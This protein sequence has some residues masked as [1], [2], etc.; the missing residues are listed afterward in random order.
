M[1]GV[2]L[3]LHVSGLV[4]LALTVTP[5]TTVSFWPPFSILLALTLGLYIY[6]TFYPLPPP[7]PSATA[8]IDTPG[9]PGVD[10]R[11]VR[12]TIFTIYGISPL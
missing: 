9:D 12:T 1:R 4:G 8:L 3:A 5:P 7:P 10:P 6:L 11:S 2:Y